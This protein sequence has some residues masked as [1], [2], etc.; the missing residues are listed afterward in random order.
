[1]AAAELVRTEV[2]QKFLAALDSLVKESLDALVSA[3]LEHL[4]YAQGVARQ[5]TVL[6]RTLRE[7]PEKAQKIL[8]AEEAAKHKENR[9]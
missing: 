3:P 2:G 7:A 4:A 6:L 9:Q 1:M 8:A 5:G